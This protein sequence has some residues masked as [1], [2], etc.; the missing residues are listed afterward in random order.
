MTNQR[1]TIQEAHELYKKGEIDL[2]KWNF[3]FIENCK[4]KEAKIN[5]W[6]YLDIANWEKKV[7]ETLDDTSLVFDK[8][9]AIPVGVKDIFN[10]IDMP[11]SMG[12]PIWEGFTPGN[13]ARVVHD[14][15]F[16]GG[17]IAG[18][19]ITAEFAVHAP[20][21]TRNPWDQDKSPG[22]S[23]SGSAAAVSAGMIPL[24]LGTQTAGS[25][26]RP[27]SYCGVFGY[28]PTF[29]TI[30]RT[31]ML[32]TTDTLDTVGFFATNIDDCELLFDVIRVKGLDYPIVNE[33]LSNVSLQSKLEKKWKVGVLIDQHPVLKNF[34]NEVMSDFK[35]LT[36]D[37]TQTNLAEIHYPK[38]PE[39]LYDAHRVQQVIYHKSLAYYFKKEFQ[40][41]TLISSVMY[42][43]VSEGNKITL[44][45]YKEALNTQNYMTSLLDKFFEE[46]DVILTPSTANVAPDFN[47]A[48]D[49]PDTCL[50]W[51]MCGCPTINIPVFEKAKLPFGL[52]VIARKY[53]DY[54]LINFIRDFTYANLFPK[55]SKIS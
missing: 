45:E 50:I 12:S 22:T 21:A 49:P 39:L 16:N 55:F 14:I 18:K 5:A 52:Q 35:K 38:I 10:T 23:S 29:G 19:T 11:T 27:A 46:Y 25:I 43:I 44:D 42:D 40:N 36:L 20:N 31:G 37:L 24:S 8:L 3:E 41:K 32:K 15:K 4:T 17:V 51:T 30:P 1:Y 33:K 48:I 54:K 34:N 28:K 7:A 13:D 47:T 9:L 53:C 6:E 2:I 26:I